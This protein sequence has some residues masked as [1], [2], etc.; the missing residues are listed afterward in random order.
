[1]LNIEKNLLFKTWLEPWELI[2]QD[3]LMESNG[4]DTSEIQDEPRQ[5]QVTGRME[6]SVFRISLRNAKEM[7]CTKER[8][9][10]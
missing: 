3:V 5:G 8:N 7:I 9:K 2:T 6:S 10:R 1:M 4:P